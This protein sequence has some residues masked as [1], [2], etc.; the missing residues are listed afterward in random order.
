MFS[1][2]HFSVFDF[3][4]GVSQKPLYRP[5]QEVGGK[6]LLEKEKSQLRKGIGQGVGLMCSEACDWVCDLSHCPTI[7]V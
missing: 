4:R 7:L 6:G 1:L 3:L 5:S 2:H